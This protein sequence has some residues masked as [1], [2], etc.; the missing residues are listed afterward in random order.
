MKTFKKLLFVIAFSLPLVSFAQTQQVNVETVPLR[1]L[2]K[3]TGSF[4]RLGG[5][6]TGGLI[7]ELLTVESDT[8]KGKAVRMAYG[9]YATMCNGNYRVEGKLKGDALELR[10]IEKAGIAGDCDM[11]LNL[12]VE[13]NKLVGTINNDKAQ[14]SR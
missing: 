5:H 9:P 2:G 3:Y 7:L 10:S 12:T 8:V 13:G 6:R 4:E 1:L 14:L 11:T